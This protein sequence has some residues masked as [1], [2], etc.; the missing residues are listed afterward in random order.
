MK[1]DSFGFTLPPLAVFRWLSQTRITTRDSF[2]I[3][4][5]VKAMLKEMGTGESTG[6]LD[7]ELRAAVAEEQGDDTMVT[8]LQG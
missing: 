5:K 6:D 4:K 3:S 7:A 1:P 2:A 8:E